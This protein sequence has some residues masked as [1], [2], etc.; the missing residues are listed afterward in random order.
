MN[1]RTVK[2]GAWVAAALLVPTLASGQ[3][4]S[5]A[6]TPVV[7][8]E[9]AAPAPFGPGERMTYKVK[10]GVV[11]VVEGH[12]AVETIDSVRGHPT[13]HITMSIDGSAM[14]GLAKVDDYWESWLD[15]R[16]LTS[17]RFIRDIHELNYK[18][19]RIF[20]IYPEQKRWERADEKGNEGK[21]LNLLPLDEIA[22]V[23]FVRTLPLEVGAT[24]EFNRYFKEDGNP[25]KV[26]V[27][28]KQRV[29]VPAGT[30]DA[31]VVQ[32]IIRTSGLFGDGGEAE[33]Y[34]SDDEHRHMVYMRSKVPLVGSITLHLESA[35]AGVPL[36][37]ASR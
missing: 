34:F 19:R 20:E 3:N 8:D 2:T 21:T 29:E 16:L 1:G 13:Y 4:G 25:V 31:I 27:L 10:L 26:K 11:T 7:T 28:R 36:N 24:Y 32:P 12:M 6:R 35:T 9:R 15:T 23:Y 37:P 14:F 33:V 18:D 22:F 30:F 17:R 5:S